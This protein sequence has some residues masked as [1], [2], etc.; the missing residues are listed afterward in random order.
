MVYEQQWMPP[1]GKKPIATAVFCHGFGE[2]CGRYE[3]LFSSLAQQG[4]AVFGFD[5]EGFGVSASASSKGKTRGVDG[6]MEDVRR[7]SRRVRID[8]VPHFLIGQ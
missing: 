6:T 8:G 7:I 5:Q 4:I 2:H 3:E 1:G